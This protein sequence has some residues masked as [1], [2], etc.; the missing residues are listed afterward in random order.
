MIKYVWKIKMRNNVYNIMFVE[1]VECNS[2]LLGWV[3]VNVYG[4]YQ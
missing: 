4:A 2:E 1:F 3:V